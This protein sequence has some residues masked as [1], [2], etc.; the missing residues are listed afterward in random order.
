MALEYIFFSGNIGIGIKQFI[1]IEAASISDYVVFLSD[2]ESKK[3][4]YQHKIYEILN[5]WK[6]NKKLISRHIIVFNAVTSMVWEGPKSL[7]IF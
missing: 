5:C 3:S 7:V 1:S 6:F 4:S 2:I